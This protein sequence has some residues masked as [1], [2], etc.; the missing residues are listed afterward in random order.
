MDIHVK[1]PTFNWS[2]DA[3]EEMEGRYQERYGVLPDAKKA[4]TLYM[5]EEGTCPF[6]KEKV[7]IGD[8]RGALE[9]MVS[10]HY[11]EDLLELR[12]LQRNAKL[13]DAVVL[14]NPHRGR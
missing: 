3:Y 8:V 5:A 6:C 11:P 4:M 14:A 9:H 13:A 10:K 2:T 7:N 1:K 12:A